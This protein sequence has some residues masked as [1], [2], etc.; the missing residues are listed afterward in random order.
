MINALT[1]FTDNQ[2][3]TFQTRSA[4]GRLLA[5]IYFAMLALAL[6]GIGRSGRIIELDLR[7]RPRRA[8]CSWSW[9]HCSRPSPAGS[10]RRA[11]SSRYAAVV[12]LPLVL[13]VALGTTTLLNPKVRVVIVGLAVA[14]GLVSSAQNVARSG[15]RAAPWPPPSTRRRSPAMSSRSAPTSSAHQST[16]NS[17]PLAI[18]HADVPARTGPQIVNSVNYA[19]TVHAADPEGSPATAV[20]QRAGTTTTCG[21]SGSRCTRPMGSSARPIATDLLGTSSQQRWRR[22]QRGDQPPCAVLRADEPH[23]VRRHRLL[24]QPGEPQATLPGGRW[25]CR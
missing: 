4:Q 24:E 25:R 21:W 1:G 9:T 3:S 22:A 17:G 19:D 13:L 14:A 8:A 20:A 11:F 23:R 10:D 7:T 2:G 6:F 15:P 12:F 16:G 18:R 5:V